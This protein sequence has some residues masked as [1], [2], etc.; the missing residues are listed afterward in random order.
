[1]FKSDTLPQDISQ[2]FLPMGISVT[3][4][5]WP[6]HID[7]LFNKVPHFEG[8]YKDIKIRFCLPASDID[9]YDYEIKTYHPTNLKLGL[10]LAKFP[11]RWKK[12]FSPPVRK[13]LLARKI[14]LWDKDLRCWAVHRDKAQAL[15][16]QGKVKEAIGEVL[17]AIKGYRQPFLIVD[18]K[19]I[20]LR[21][22]DKLPS[23]GVLDALCRLNTILVRGSNVLDSEVLM[24]N[25]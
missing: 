13:S 17:E 3:K 10:T 25:S 24:V 21:F 12:F 4:V 8:F 9:G 6:R 23:Q 18:D 14:T 15:L 2:H 19:K 1:M 22:D 16:G 7:A 5:W 11:G 20:S